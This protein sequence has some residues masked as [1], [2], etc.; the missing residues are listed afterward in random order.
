MLID[1]DEPLL[2][3]A[4]DVDQGLLVAS[5]ARTFVS[6]QTIQCGNTLFGFAGASETS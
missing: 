3:K 6:I 2:E 4:V 1:I 5:G